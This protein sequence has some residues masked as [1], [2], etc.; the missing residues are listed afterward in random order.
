MILQPQHLGDLHLN[1]HFAA[2]VAE[3]VVL[4][5]IHHFGFLHRTVVQPKDDIAVRVKVGAC[6]GNWLIVDV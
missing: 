6:Y 3:Q 5:G 4:S 1:G 2:H